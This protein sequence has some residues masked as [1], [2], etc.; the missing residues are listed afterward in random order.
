MLKKILLIFVLFLS[1]NMVFAS[2]QDGFKFLNFNTNPE[3][4]KFLLSYEINYLGEFE[5]EDFFKIDFYFNGKF[6]KTI[7]YEPL[8]YEFDLIFLKK[9]CEV[10]KLGPGEYQFLAYVLRDGIVYK[11]LYNNHFIS[12][13]GL[14]E[15]SFEDLENGTLVNIF[16][17]SQLDEVTLYHDIP[18]SVI[19]RLTYENRESL[20]DTEFDYVIIKENPLIAWNIQSP[21][22][23]VSYKLNKQLTEEE[24]LNFRVDMEETPQFLFFKYFV[25]LLFVLVL[26]LIFR[27]LIKKKKNK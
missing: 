16:V 10:E 11:Y 6:E 22:K 2:S 7:C 17:D 9:T 18:K 19:E 26:I 5:E 25:M 4:E 21:P 1:L 27:P 14:V 15:L 20:I 23:N 12:D 24:K 3:L 13:N 8:N